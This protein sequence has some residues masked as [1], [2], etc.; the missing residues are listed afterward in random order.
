[1]TTHKILPGPDEQRV[2]NRETRPRSV[3]Q[4]DQTIPD[5]LDALGGQAERARRGRGQ[6]NGRTK[7]T[8]D[9]LLTWILMWSR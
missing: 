6:H 7:F 1:M 4:V 5:K 8:E 3:V 2:R 9:A